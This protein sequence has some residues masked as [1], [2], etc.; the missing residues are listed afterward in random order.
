M[1]EKI[2]VVQVGLGPIGTEAARLA[3]EKKALQI[4]GG[5]D[6]DKGKVNKALG[7]ILGLKSLH[8]V[9]V[10]ND[11]AK[12]LE[13]TRPDIVLHST[14]SFLNNVEEQLQM[15][16]RAGA[17]VVSSCEELF[18]PYRRNSEFCARID[19][20]AR[21]HSATVLG[22]GVN[23]GYSLDFFVLSASS[24]CTHI[25]SI[26]ATR[27]SNAGRRR[28]PLQKK[29]GAGLTV[30]QFKT[31]VAQGK[32]GHIGLLESLHAVFDR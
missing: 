16:L 21:E 14:G 26:R 19:R 3:H 17:S 1:A 27:V 11:L 6:I 15:C 2:R 24:V 30:D 12:V 25:E 5:I 7:E 9:V 8:D 10:S 29:V 28:L 22:T 32:L 20:L 23:P 13:E 4:V 31:L 18:Y